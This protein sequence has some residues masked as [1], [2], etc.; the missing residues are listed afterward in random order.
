MV[1]QNAVHRYSDVLSR[2]HSA[3]GNGELR[4]ELHI[5]PP[6]LRGTD[7]KPRALALAFSPDG[8]TLAVN[9]EIDHLIYLLETITG[10][11]RARFMGH[12]DIE[13]SLAFSPDGRRLASGSWDTTALVWDAT[14]RPAAARIGKLSAEQAQALW[15]D[16]ASKD[17]RKAFESIGLL[18]ASPEQAVPLLKSKLRPAPKPVEPRQVARLIADLGS[19]EFA[20]RDKAM[21]QLRQLGERA[22]TALTESLKNKPSLEARKRIE[23]LLERIRALSTSPE[24]LREIR[25]IEVLEHVGTA[26]ATLRRSVHASQRFCEASLNG[27]Y[28]GLSK[29]AEKRR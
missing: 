29:S 8:K 25:A 9:N 10:K 7:R 26:E 28:A 20:V 1:A 22:E 5:E 16:L 17:A 2:W 13:W 11:E 27:G 21:E 24:R 3:R 18:T 15:T 19:D 4:A 23:E 12:Q 14:S 6:K